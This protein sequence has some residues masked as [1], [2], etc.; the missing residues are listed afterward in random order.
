MATV[1]NTAAAVSV[2]LERQRQIES[3]GWTAEHDDQHHDMGDLASAGAAYALAGADLLD[4]YSDDRY[5]KDN[6][7]D[8][9]PAGWGKHWWKPADPRR[10][11]VKAAALILA[12]IERLDRLCEKRGAAK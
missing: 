1:A 6:P 4:P 8:V 5:G 10:N 3:E 2:L 7:P 12:E 11:L 9:W